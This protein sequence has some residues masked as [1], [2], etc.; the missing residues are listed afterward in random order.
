[1]IDQHYEEKRLQQ[2]YEVF[3][4][5]GNSINKIV[6]DEGFVKANFASYK[7]L[8]YFRS[9]RKEIDWRNEMLNQT[10]SLMLLPDYPYKDQLAQWRQILRDWSS[11][12]D[13]PET[14]PVSFDEFLS[15]E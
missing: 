13:F 14:R 7:L 1:M 9:P 12:E 8:P 15:Q 11:T 5:Q 3:D 10:D 4:E 2:Q 6:A